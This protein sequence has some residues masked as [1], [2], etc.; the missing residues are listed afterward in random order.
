MRQLRFR[1]PGSLAGICCLWVT[2]AFLQSG[3]AWAGLDE[4]VAAW[5]RS[6]YAAALRE[7]RPL[8]EQGNAVAQFGLGLMYAHGLGVPQ[9]HREAVKWYRLAAQ[10]GNAVA[11]FGLG[12]MYAGGLGVPKDD[13]EAVKWV[14]RAAEQGEASA[15]LYLGTMYANGQGVPKDDREAVKW[16]R[17][18][19]EQ[20][21]TNAQLMLGLMYHLGQGVP[22]DYVQAHLW[23]NLAA[24]QGYSEAGANRDRVTNLMTPAQVAE[25]Q[26]LARE[27]RPR[28]ETSSGPDG[29]MRTGDGLRGPT[30][31][32]VQS[33]GTG[34]MISRDGRILTNHHV[35]EG[36]AEVRIPPYGPGA[37]LAADSRNDLALLRTSKGGNLPVAFR[38]SRGIRLGE[39][40]VVIGFP[41]WGLLATSPSVTTGT[42]SA[43]AG[44]G[45]DSRLLQ[46]SAPV[47][48]GNSGGPLLDEGGHVIGV[49]VSKLDALKVAEIT[50]DLPQNVNF[51]ISGAVVRAFLE[52]QGIAYTTAAS[53]KS[54]STAEIAE[55]ARNFTVVV[56]CWR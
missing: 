38:E 32:T 1:W 35:I 7:L 13:R 2:I 5:E 22:Q 46:I 51:A 24:A 23:F 49:V 16:Y 36:C 18:A 56:E 54:L 3:P 55:A 45:N 40:V 10:Q 20:G 27:W 12:V 19:A 29:P 25:A 41:L 44:P 31:R 26:R 28:P 30:L 47:Q 42:V 48:P 11:Q 17:R 39:P 53:T 43:L 21:D 6:D 4:G 15:Q 52:G 8:A 37:L 33:T 34:F 9:D 14:H 50:G